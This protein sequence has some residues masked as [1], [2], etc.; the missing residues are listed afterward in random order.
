VRIGG[1][2]VFRYSP[3]TTDGWG[4]STSIGNAAPG[5]T[6]HAVLPLKPGVYLIKAEDSS[7]LQSSDAASVIVTQDTII[8]LSLVSTITQDP[9][10]SGTKTNC[11]VSGGALSL[12][13]TT[14]PG[15]YTFSSFM[16]LTTVQRVRLTS[17]IQAVVINPL[18]TI[19]SRTAN[20][21]TWTDFDGTSSADADAIVFVRSTQTDPAGSPVWTAWNRLDSGEF[22]ARGFQFKVELVSYDSTFNISISELSVKA[23]KP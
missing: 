1:K 18:D 21:D 4:N 22:V 5:N 14:L 16:D 11:T 3:T 10:F 20:I 8:A 9:T 23:E 12:T 7:G 17:R 19:D 6:N 13:D 2:Y 15:T